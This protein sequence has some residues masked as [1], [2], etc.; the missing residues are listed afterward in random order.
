ML[1][2][3]L[4]LVGLIISLI[5]NRF[6]PSKIFFAAT[7]VL[8]IGGEVTQNVLLN[9][10]VNRSIVTLLLLLLSAIALER[11]YLLIWASKRL[12]HQSYKV[13]L[14]RLAVI[15]SVSSAFLN[16]TAVV[17]TLIGT[18]L[19]N[20]FH[21]AKKLLIPLS[22]FSILGGTLTLIGTATNLV[23]SGLLEE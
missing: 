8:Y 21:S 13:T 11:T 19:K 9:N 20:Q 2:T 6:A 12:F 15:S 10:S 14:F 1:L 7:A 23:V 4:V 5:S 22:Y 17:A 3:A 16:N 18:V